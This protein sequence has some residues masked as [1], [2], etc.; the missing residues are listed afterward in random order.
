MTLASCD[1]GSSHPF[2]YARVLGIY[3]ANVVYVGPRMLDYRPRRVEFLRVRWYCTIDSARPG[4]AVRKLDRVQFMPVVDNDAFGF[5]NPSDVVR[6]CHI[7][8]AFASGK[9]HVDGKGLSHCTQDSSD[10][11]TYYINR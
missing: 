1:D 8:P 3:H 6:G 11:V 9:L 7:I 10:W 4:Q 5:V 2:Q